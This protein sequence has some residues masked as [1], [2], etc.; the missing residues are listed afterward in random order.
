MVTEQ[1]WRQTRR[2]PRGQP[3]PA[4]PPVGSKGRNVLMCEFHRRAVEPRKAEKIKDVTFSLPTL[5]SGHAADN[6]NLGSSTLKE[7]EV[8]SQQR[9]G[10]NKSGTAAAVETVVYSKA[11]SL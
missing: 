2:A 8:M 5:W 3:R 10:L 9:A 7:E 1:L 11:A 6:L 4:F